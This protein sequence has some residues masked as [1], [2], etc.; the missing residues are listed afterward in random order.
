MLSLC[1]TIQVIMNIDVALSGGISESVFT[2]S[3]GLLVQSK[4][5][6]DALLHFASRKKVSRYESVMDFLLCQ[7]FPAF[8]KPCL[9]YYEGRGKKLIEQISEKQIKQIDLMLFVALNM[10]TSLQGEYKRGNWGHFARLAKL[11]DYK[12]VVRNIINEKR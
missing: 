5:H 2:M 11:V 3:E 12:Q 10:A 7:F 1:C 9:E 8:E 4:K 6:Y